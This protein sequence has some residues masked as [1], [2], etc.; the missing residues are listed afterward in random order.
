MTHYFSKVTPF[1]AIIGGVTVNI[2]LTPS[3][4]KN[5]IKEFKRYADGFVYVRVSVIS[6]PEKD[7]ANKALIKLLKKSWKIKDVEILNGEKSRQKLVLLNGIAGDI[8]QN[9][10]KCSWQT[11][12]SFLTH[13]GFETNKI[14]KVFQL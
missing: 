11:E 10:T 8:L 6:P 7:K 5:E 2:R 13:S 4:S 1:S 3:S 14:K 12:R 9:I